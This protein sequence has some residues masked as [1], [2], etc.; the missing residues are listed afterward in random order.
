[1]VEAAEKDDEELTEEFDL[2][3][4]IDELVDTS[5]RL[6]RLE[7]AALFLLIGAPIAIIAKMAGGS[8]ALIFIGAT[9]A[10]MPLALLM[11]RATEELAIRSGPGLSAFM[12]ATFG[13]ATELIIAIVAINRGHIDLARASLVGS[14]IIN[15][16]LVLGL[17]F[18]AGGI[19]FPVMNF[20][21]I[22]ASATISML[23]VSV[24]GVMLPSLYFYATYGFEEIGDFPD[25][26]VTMSLFVAAVLIGVYL[27]YMLFSM[28]THKRYFDGQEG[29]PIERT[30]K[31]EPDLATWPARTAVLML[32]VTMVCVV[33]IAELMIGEIEHIMEG[34]GVSEFFMGVVII[35]LV[36][37]AAEHSSAILMAWR[38]RIEL[39]VQIALGS[40]VQIALLVIPIMVI[41]SFAIGNFMAMV[42][43][44]LGL[45]AMVATLVIAIVIVLDGQ[46][47][48]FDGAMLV[49]IFLLLAGIAFM[50]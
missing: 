6:S 32:A 46:A 14:I 42:F 47:T 45:I 16:L 31:P 33:G 4:E 21:R 34:A 13:N 48:W 2:G 10:I 7:K 18:L 43:T 24:V 5:L 29:V 38:G 22:T 50:L 17:S 49:A 26:I 41:I 25:E 35:A 36:G 12:L 37:N 15:V 30:R 1:M 44:P 40:S 9:A 11:G 39:S 28:R 3:E 27:L 23:T 20:S 19:K 8:S